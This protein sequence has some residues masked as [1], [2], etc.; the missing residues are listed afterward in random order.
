[1]RVLFRIESWYQ[2]HDEDL[3]RKPRSSIKS[4]GYS[5]DTVP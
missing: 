1:M 3:R 5:H 4:A 2:K